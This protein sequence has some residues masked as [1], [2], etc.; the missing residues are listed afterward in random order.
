MPLTDE[1]KD[2][3]L[4]AFYVKDNGEI[5][6]YKVT[7]QGKYLVFE[8]N[9][10]STYV[11]GGNKKVEN[12]KTNDSL[13]LWVNVGFVSLVGIAIISLNKKKLFV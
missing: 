4:M 10:F 8:T 12:P 11:I 6:N 3:D 1:L 7:I 5:E 9:H 13:T 2:L